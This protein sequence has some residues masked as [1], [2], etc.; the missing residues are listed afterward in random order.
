MVQPAVSADAIFAP[1]EPMS[2]AFRRGHARLPPPGSD[3]RP[4]V[5]F[6]RR[7]PAAQAQWRSEGP[8]HQ[9][10]DRVRSGDVGQVFGVALDD[11]PEMSGHRRPNIY[12][13]GDFSFRPQPG[14]EPRGCRSGTQQARRR[15]CELCARWNGQRGWRNGLSGSIWKIDGAT[16]EIS[17]FTTIAARLGDI[18]FD[19][20][21]TIFA[22]DRQRPRLSAARTAPLSTA[23]TMA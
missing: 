21:P 13:G 16:G 18:V 8:A 4:D 10:P 19:L 14:R 23:S 20:E 1:G 2:R 9:H 3:R 5:H 22:S 17:L 15:R 6:L 11:A 7:H 12:V